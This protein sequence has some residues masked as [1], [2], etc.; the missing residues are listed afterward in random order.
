M[1]NAD[2]TLNGDLGDSISAKTSGSVISLKPLSTSSFDEND[3]IYD[4]LPVVINQPPLITK[5]MMAASKPAIVPYASA[6]SSGKNL[7][8][9]PDGTVKV[10]LG[11]SFQLRIEARQPSVYNVENGIPIIKP[12]TADL[13]YVWRF[14]EELT[15]TNYISSL[16]SKI[17]IEKNEL[18][19]TR[20]QPQHAGTYVCEVSNDIGTTTSET[21][22]I[23]VLNPDVDSYFYT[24]LV[25]NGNAKL[26]VDNW[27]ANNEDFIV[28][29]FTNADSKDLRTPNRVDVFG[30]TTDTMHPRP[31]QIDSG[32][33]K[34]LTYTDDFIG[35][36][37]GLYF[38]R[39]PYK[40]EAA[41]GNI[42]VKAYQDI[43]VT[44]LQDLIKGSIYGIDGVRAVFGC[45][46]G[47]GVGSY[48]PTRELVLPENRLNVLNYF[49][50]APRVSVENFLLAGPGRIEDRAYVT[51]EEYDQETRLASKLLNNDGSTAVQGNTIT[52]LDPYQKRFKKFSGQ[53]YYNEDK[54]KI[55]QLSKGDGTDQILFAA[56][57]LYPDLDSRPNYGQYLEFNKVVIE[58]LNPKTTKIRIGIHFFTNDWRIFNTADYLDS[59]SEYIFETIGWERNYKRGTFGQDGT[60]AE[61][62][63]IRSILNGNEK[64]KDKPIIEQVPLAPTPRVAVTGLSLALFP[65][66][67]QNKAATDYYTNVS[68]AKNDT[69][70]TALPVVLKKNLS[71]DPYGSTTRFLHVA[72]R[73]ISKQGFEFKPNKTVKVN[74]ISGINFS[75]YVQNQPRTHFSI[76]EDTFFPFEKNSKVQIIGTSATTWKLAAESD[77]VNS[78]TP[79]NIEVYKSPSGSVSML[80]SASLEKI[81]T[82][83][84]GVKKGFSSYAY[85]AEIKNASWQNEFAYTVYYMVRPPSGST[86]TSE[87]QLQRNSYVLHIKWDKQNREIYL[88]RAV[89]TKGGKGE[90]SAKVTDFQLD[91]N[92]RFT[93]ALPKELLH[94]P[95][96]QGGLGIPY[97]P[98]NIS[99]SASSIFDILQKN[100]DSNNSNNIESIISTISFP[101]DDAL[102]T[103]ASFKTDIQSYLYSTASDA[104]TTETLQNKYGISDDTQL[105]ITLNDVLDPDYTTSLYAVTIVPM[106]TKT[107]QGKQIPDYGTPVSGSDSFGFKYKIVYGWISDKQTQI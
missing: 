13:T 84:W 89:A 8:L 63:W 6:D 29:E 30:Y 66:E 52:L 65:I 99:G 79:Y 45:Y 58:R 11:T 28:S 85:P 83:V 76:D 78:L 17:E 96:L 91:P 72:F 4:L 74:H 62:D 60:T 70:A 67:R 71:Y 32:F 47:N 34:N 101:S 10:M 12:A 9:F 92:G 80:T 57:D 68:L 95:I 54:Y 49:P 14:N 24:N 3:T 105:S 64:Y 31:Y 16:Q 21:I 100:P 51:L 38:T 48:I 15:T 106:R 18:T 46:I 87:S 97:K 59:N 61:V 26:G 93:F 73:H 82:G 37:K 42:L 88:R 86:V 81:K 53:R 56:E 33:I 98:Q 25:E 75:S 2:G 19:I 104:V 107:V 69:P 7:Y 1:R 27:D 35:N 50:G 90:L 36:G 94:T 102:I 40:F 103:T 5:S 77:Y 23:E 44:D 55:N 20:I 43:D 39:T 41:G 22:T